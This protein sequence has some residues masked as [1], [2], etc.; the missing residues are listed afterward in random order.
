MHNIDLILNEIKVDFSPNENVVSI[1]ERIFNSKRKKGSRLYWEINTNLR[2]FFVKYSPKE[3]D[4]VFELEYKAL[5]KLLLLDFNVPVPVKLIKNGLVTLR[6]NG[7]SLEDIII[8]G[9]LEN[10]AALLNDLFIKIARF[11]KKYTVE[12]SNKDKDEK[13]KEV[14]A[15]KNYQEIKNLGSSFNIGFTHGDFDP[16]NTFFEKSNNSFSVVDWEN[17]NEFGVQELDII[18]FLVMIGVIANPKLSHK[19]LYVLI[20]G[21]KESLYINLLKIY[22]VERSIE[23]EAVLKLV[24]AYC[25]AQNLRLDK[26]GRNK[27][28]F[29][30]NQFKELFYAK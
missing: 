14:T 28:D 27:R 2:A 12:L 4:D 11:H 8:K 23:M 3:R 10:N 5:E 26:A 17:F 1:K 6:I 15:W 21:N 16:F 13:F 22:C 24:P 20:F 30:F 29:L 18:H 7:Q 9:G 25:D 19:E